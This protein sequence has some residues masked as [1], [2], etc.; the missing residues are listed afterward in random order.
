MDGAFLLASTC[1]LFCLG[2][3]FAEALLPWWKARLWRWGW[4][5]S[6]SSCAVTCLGFQS[7]SQGSEL[8]WN[9]GCSKCPWGPGLS[10]WLQL[11]WWSNP[12]FVKCLAILFERNWYTCRAGCRMVSSCLLNTTLFGNGSIRVRTHSVQEECW[13]QH[14]MRCVGFHLEALLQKRQNIAF[15]LLPSY[16][17]TF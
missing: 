9:S 2:N 10:T 11:F 5:Q 16:E 14:F 6:N 1:L 8:P 12:Y 7:I 4:A 15:C 3:V 17:Q 13:W